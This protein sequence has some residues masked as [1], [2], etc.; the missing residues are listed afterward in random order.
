MDTDTQM[1]CISREWLKKLGQV[2]KKASYI[3]N[4]PDHTQL[5]L[6]KSNSL[7]DKDVI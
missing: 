2:A 6:M 1:F 7:N 5:C 3:Y 4:F